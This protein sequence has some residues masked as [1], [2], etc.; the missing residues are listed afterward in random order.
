MIEKI[1]QYTIWHLINSQYAWHVEILNWVWETKWNERNAVGST[2]SKILYT[3]A[4]HG[5]MDSTQV[6]STKFYE[7]QESIILIVGQ[8]MS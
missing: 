5:F 1:S 7:I 8:S 6:K 3:T 2:S 4:M